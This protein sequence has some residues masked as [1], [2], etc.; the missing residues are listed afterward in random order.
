MVLYSLKIILYFYIFPRPLLNKSWEGK[1]LFSFSS[2]HF[3]FSCHT[4]KY[5]TVFDYIKNITS[6][7]YPH[8]Q[9]FWIHV[10]W[11]QA[12]VIL[13]TWE[14]YSELIWVVTCLFRQRILVFL[15]DL[16]NRVTEWS[17]KAKNK[18]LTSQM[19]NRCDTTL[20]QNT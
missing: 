12:A 1:I 17:T 4:I 11:N 3:K 20:F 16:Q 7:V 6:N 8:L 15:L 10:C 14:Q 13:F 18:T 2:K 9:N 5:F 19:K